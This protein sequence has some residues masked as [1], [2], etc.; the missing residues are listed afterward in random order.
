MIITNY[1]PHLWHP[2]IKN[3]GPVTCRLGGAEEQSILLSE[4][5]SMAETF[6]WGHPAKPSCSWALK[7]D[8]C[9]I[10]PR[11]WRLRCSNGDTNIPPNWHA[12]P[13]CV[14]YP[15]YQYQHMFYPQLCFNGE[16]PAKQLALMGR[17]TWVRVAGNQHWWKQFQKP[18]GIIDPPAPGA[19]TSPDLMQIM[20]R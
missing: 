20:Q 5:H 16:Y 7:M 12:N 1:T 2:V 19:V 18:T 4:G 9:Q 14:A 17:F 15:S 3:N 11:S 8:Q 10:S 6:V 13:A